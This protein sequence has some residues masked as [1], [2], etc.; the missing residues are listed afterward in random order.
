MQQRPLGRTLP[1]RA[2]RAGALEEDSTPQCGCSRIR[3]HSGQT[4]HTTHCAQF[5]H[6]IWNEKTQFIPIRNVF[7]MTCNAR[8]PSLHQSNCVV[9]MQSTDLHRIAQLK[10]ILTMLVDF[11]SGSLV[12]RGESFPCGKRGN[13][14]RCAAYNIVNMH[15]SMPRHGAPHSAGETT[16]RFERVAFQEQGQ[17]AQCSP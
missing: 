17:L 14:E 4:R 8:I 7:P 13:W 1:A 15:I 11:E 5:M 3:E 10:G 16:K 6:S 9:A 12:K 2:C